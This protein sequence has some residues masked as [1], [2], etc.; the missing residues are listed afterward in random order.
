TLW[1]RD[2]LALVAGSDEYLFNS[3]QLDDLKRFTSRFGSPRGIVQALRSVETAQRN[4][5]LQLQL[6]P[7]VLQL[8]ID[9]EQALV[10]G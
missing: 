9:L 1:L 4:V 6:R 2:A 3:D 7:V 10:T 5:R 8:V